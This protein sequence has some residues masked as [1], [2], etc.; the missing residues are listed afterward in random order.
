[1]ALQ[2][3]V[4]R[5]PLPQLLPALLGPVSQSP[6]PY[7]C[8]SLI[9]LGCLSCFHLVSSFR[10]FS[11]YIFFTGWGCQPQGQAPNLEDHGIPFSLGHHLVLSDKGVHTSSHTTASIA[12]QNHMT[13]QAPPLCQRRDTFRGRQRGLIKTQN[14]RM[15]DE[16][17]RI[18]YRNERVKKH[19]T[20]I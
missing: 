15:C 3:L 8:K 11:R 4:D 9:M 12:L 14:S 2:S 19:Y 1:M 17:G 20:Y 16:V 6:I 5:K 7:T 13:A 10:R 18:S